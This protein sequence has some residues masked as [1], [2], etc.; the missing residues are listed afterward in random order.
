MPVC[1]FSTLVVLFDN[2]LI[3]RIQPSGYFIKLLCKQQDRYLVVYALFQHAKLDTAQQ[4]NTKHR[5]ICHLRDL[6]AELNRKRTE[7]HLKFLFEKLQR[8]PS[9][10]NVHFRNVGHTLGWRVAVKVHAAV[11]RTPEWG[12]MPALDQL[13]RQKSNSSLKGFPRNLKKS[14]LYPNFHR[15]KR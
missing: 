8:A 14:V 7:Q 13:K 15:Q 4:H 10:L 6:T 1:Y 12:S 9:L 5:Y 11:A 2:I 3:Y